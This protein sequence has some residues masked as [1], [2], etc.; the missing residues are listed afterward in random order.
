MFTSDACQASNSCLWIIELPQDDHHDSVIQSV[1]A[2]CYYRLS[3]EPSNR[4]PSSRVLVYNGW[5]RW[6]SSCVQKGKLKIQ[7][8]NR[9][10]RSSTIL[11]RGS[12]QT[13][14]SESLV[15][16]NHRLP[17]FPC[18][19]YLALDHQGG[20]KPDGFSKVKR[21]IKGRRRWTL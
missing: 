4:C 1:E 2:N 6:L 3:C 7:V 17:R 5:F 16:H 11:W 18:P 8:L 10:T 13:T 14:H 9:S 19:M 20:Q 15:V 12:I 21:Y